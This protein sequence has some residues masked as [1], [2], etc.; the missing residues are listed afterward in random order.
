MQESYYAWSGALIQKAGGT[1]IKCIGDA[2]MIAFPADEASRAIEA[3]LDLKQSGDQWLKQ[4]Q[5]PC[6]HLVKVHL[7][8][9]VAGPIGTPGAERLDIYGKTVN[10]CVTMESDGWAM[11]PQVFR[12]LDT[13]TRTKFK[14]HTPPVT[15][16]RVADSH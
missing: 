13:E 1:V 16:I 9:V 15:Y 10:L 8:P 4:K 14:K 11:S 7:G 12:A 5:I 3:L 2:L 6:H